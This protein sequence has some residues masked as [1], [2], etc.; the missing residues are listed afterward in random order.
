[1]KEGNVE[2]QTT[3]DNIEKALEFINSI[4][5]TREKDRYLRILEKKGVVPKATLKNKKQEKEDSDIGKRYLQ[6]Q[7]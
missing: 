7:T 6:G 1:M 4:E 2:I 3:N 5:N